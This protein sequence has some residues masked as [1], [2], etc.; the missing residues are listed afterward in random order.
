MT[1]LYFRVRLAVVAGFAGGALAAMLLPGRYRGWAALAAALI[2]IL[3]PF[4][5]V[6]WR[7][8]RRQ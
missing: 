5:Y 1:D 8:R 7:R 6:R 4:V 3:A 2:G